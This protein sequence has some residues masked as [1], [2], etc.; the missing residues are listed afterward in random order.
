[1]ITNFKVKKRY[2]LNGDFNHADP[3]TNSDLVH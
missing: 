2:I 3:R 1:M